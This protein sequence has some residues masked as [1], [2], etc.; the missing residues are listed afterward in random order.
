MRLTKQEALL[1]RR[2]LKQ[3]AALQLEL[4]GPKAVTFSRW[5]KREAQRLDK[6][7]AKAR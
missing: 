1:K 2:K 6:V 5:F 4:G 7:I 3:L